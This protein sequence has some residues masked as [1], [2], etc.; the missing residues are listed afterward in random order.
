MTAATLR[1]RTSRGSMRMPRRPS[2]PLMDCEVKN[3]RSLSPVPARP[4]TRP[5]PYS[6]FSRTPCTSTSS[7][8]RTGAAPAGGA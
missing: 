2:M 8:T 1:V 3:T 5:Y 6:A 7:F 4:T